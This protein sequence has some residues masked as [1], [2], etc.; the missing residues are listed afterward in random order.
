MEIKTEKSGNTEFLTVSIHMEIGGK[1]GR[2]KEKKYYSRGRETHAFTLD[3]AGRII[4]MWDRMFNGGSTY[5]YDGL[6]QELEK[7]LPKRN[8][9]TAEEVFK[10]YWVNLKETINQEFEEINKGEKGEYALFPVEGDYL[11]FC[12]SE[13]ING[14]ERQPLPVKYGFL[15]WFHKYLFKGSFEELQDDLNNIPQT[16]KDLIDANVTTP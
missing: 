7:K 5:A 15:Y 1:L 10:K 8:N 4:F 12:L 9:E 13:A 14:F 2:R 16:I 3:D 11:I 6:M